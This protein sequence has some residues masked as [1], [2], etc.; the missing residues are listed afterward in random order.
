M[1]DVAVDGI[2]RTFARHEDEIDKLMRRVR[3]LEANLSKL[4]G[5]ICARL[6]EEADR[7][8]LIQDEVAQQHRPEYGN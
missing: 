1:N 3:D 8:K 4:D 5:Q 7:R 6:M 2:Y